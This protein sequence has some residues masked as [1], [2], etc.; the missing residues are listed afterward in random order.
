MRKIKTI[1]KRIC[2]GLLTA[3]L[4]LTT[5]NLP[6]NVS[7]VCAAEAGART[8]A[9]GNDLFIGGNYIELGLRSTGVFG[10]TSSA[11]TSGNVVFHPRRW[12]SAYSGS[13]GL[14]SNGNKVWSE[15]L[16]TGND[17]T[18][19]FFLPGTIDEGWLMGWSTTNG[20]AATYQGRPSA[21]RRNVRL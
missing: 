11:P 4:V 10:T 3:A 19:D 7:I 15:G 5:V 18:V 14:R 13:I 20:Q 12:T 1:A 8:Y 21:S 17:E 9:S 6:E 16:A 2:L